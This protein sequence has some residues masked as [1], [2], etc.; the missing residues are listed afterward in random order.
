MLRASIVFAGVCLWVCLSVRRK[1]RKLLIGNLCNLVGIC[2]MVNVRC[3]CKLMTFDLWPW[4]LSHFSNLGY[5][6][7]MAWLHFQFGDTSSRYLDH[8]L[9]SRSWLQDQG[10]AREKAV[11]CNLKTTGRKF[12]GLDRNIRYYSARSNSE[13][14]TFWPWH[15]SYYSEFKLQV[16]NALS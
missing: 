1:S 9:A 13:L 16:L 10:H 2:P 12:L 3:G 4:K 14:L 5:T 6:F 7:R 11:A 8:G 15:I